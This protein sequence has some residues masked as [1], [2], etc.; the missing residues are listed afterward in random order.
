MAEQV[1][2]L[3][4]DILDTVISVMKSITFLG[5]SVFYWSIG[6]LIMSAVITYLI[7]TANSSGE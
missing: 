7:N 3:I 4:F 5:I 2:E 6:F 1:F